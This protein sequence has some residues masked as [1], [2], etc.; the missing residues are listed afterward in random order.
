MLESYVPA[1]SFVI[2]KAGAPLKWELRV[3]QLYKM[4]AAK[5]FKKSRRGRGFQQNPQGRQPCACAANSLSCGS[6]ANS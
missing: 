5:R 6:S 2:Q 3:F 4:S 1:F